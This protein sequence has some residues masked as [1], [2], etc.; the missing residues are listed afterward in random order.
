MQ[1]APTIPGYKMLSVLGKGAMACVYRAEHERLG[2]EVA[3]KVLDPAIARDPEF[4]ER[5]LREA[6]AAA[7]I[8]HGNIVRALDAGIHEKVHYFVMELVRG[9][10]LRS[11]LA[12]DGRIG[13][14]E[15]LSIARNVALGLAEAN[16]LGIVHRDVKPENILISSEGEVKLADLGLVKS[17]SEDVNLT[18]Q[19]YT[20]GTVA[21]FS[22]EQARGDRA[23]D[24]RTDLYSLGATLYVMLTGELPFG[25]GANAPETMRRIIKEDPIPVDEHVPEVSAAAVQV[26]ERLMEKDRDE[27]PTTPEEAV[28]L[29][30]RARAARKDGDPGDLEGRPRRPG[31]SSGARSPRRR[32]RFGAFSASPRERALA[33]LVALISFG[34][35]ALAGLIVY[36][37]VRSRLGIPA[38]IVPLT[39]GG[40]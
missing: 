18:R 38:V 15:A 9:E 5:F 7:R 33:A 1:G 16:R 17:A 39:G 19:G 13:E 3:V 37:N 2:K 31:S 14:D 24:T 21:F 11:R 26:V 10:D 32:R 29:I 22:P 27:R 8:N 36:R 40:R 35:G 20:L 28:A 6:R 4:R 12:R 23:I 30:D 25:K 34:A